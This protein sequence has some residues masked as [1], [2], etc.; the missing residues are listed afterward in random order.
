MKPIIKT[1]K[2]WPRPLPQNRSAVTIYPFILFR[3]PE[4]RRKWLDHEMVHIAQVEEKGWF[5]FYSSY[6]W[7]HLRYGYK[8]NK[9]EE[10]ASHK[11]PVDKNR[12]E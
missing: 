10:E 8:G 12:S 11:D 5:R 6:I 4:A 9:Y 7:H 3:T 2:H 1:L